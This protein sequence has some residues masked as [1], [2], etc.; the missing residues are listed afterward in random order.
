MRCAE[1]GQAAFNVYLELL[2]W[3]DRAYLT[4]PSLLSYLPLFLLQEEVRRVPRQGRP[5]P[6]RQ[7]DRDPDLPVQAP[8]HAVRWLVVGF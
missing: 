8:S 2:I 6:G 3:L 7:V 5:R 4:R 1:L